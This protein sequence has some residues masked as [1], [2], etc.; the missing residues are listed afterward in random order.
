MKMYALY[1]SSFVAT[2]GMYS[3]DQL[4]TFCSVQQW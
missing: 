3:I 2:L 1:S 4:H